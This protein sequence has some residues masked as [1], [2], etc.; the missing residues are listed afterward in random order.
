MAVWFQALDANKMEV[1]R[2]RTHVEFQPGEFRGCIGCHETKSQAV[3]SPTHVVSQAL[4][5]EP[6]RPTPPPWGAT[7]LMDF[8]RMIQPIFESHCVACH[9]D[10]KPKGNLRLTARRDRYGF[11][12]SYRSLFGIG[13]HDPTP[14]HC[15][16]TI[17]GVKF[18][19][20]AEAERAFYWGRPAETC[21][22]PEGALIC[23]S[24]YQTGTQITQPRQFG[25]FRSPFIQ[26]LLSDPAHQRIKRGM[27]PAEWETL[28]TWVDVNAPY[29]S[30]HLRYAGSGKETGWILEPV[31]IELD[32]PF[33]KGEKGFAI[34]EWRQKLTQS[35]GGM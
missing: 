8:E 15:S 1:R 2:M 34:K 30:M 28:V 22:M 13:P 7:E 20:H 10:T 35:N 23:L 4:H 6:V 17:D 32:P 29:H 27:K 16:H 5:G 12:Q 19:S 31:R 24:N 14:T 18:E 3:P 21:F 25:S 26:K 11:M 33:Q 9:G